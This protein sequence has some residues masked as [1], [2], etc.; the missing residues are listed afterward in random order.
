MKK[1]STKTGQNDQTKE[2]CWDIYTQK[3]KGNTRKMTAWGNKPE[4][5]CEGRLKRHRQRVKQYRQ[6]RTFQN[7]EKKFY[8]QQGGDDTKTYQQPDARKTERSWTKMWQAKKHN[9]KSKW[10]NNVTKE[11]EGLEEG[12]KAEIHRFTQNDNIYIYIYIYIYIKLAN[13]R[14]RWNTGRDLLLANKPRVVPWGRER[15]PQRI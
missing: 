12:P 15:M 8:Q 5:S 11:L 4:G 1:K 2:K 13:A 14:P 7:N 6:N 9:E 10:I 3:G